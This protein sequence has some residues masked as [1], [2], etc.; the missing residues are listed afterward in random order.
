MK[1]KAFKFTKK[2]NAQLG[3]NKELYGIEIID[4]KECYYFE[5]EII[6]L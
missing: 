6:I 5:I 1:T 4:L 2:L 3:F